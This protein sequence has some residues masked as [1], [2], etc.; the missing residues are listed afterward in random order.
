MYVLS[1]P[2]SIAP[3]I[4]RTRSLLFRPFR[5]SSFLKLCAVAVF[6]E[7]YSSGNFNSLHPHHTPNAHFAADSLTFQSNPL[8]IAFILAAALVVVG[9]AIA[10]FYLLVRLRFALFH[11][12]IHQMRLLAPGWR[13][14]REQSLRFFLLSLAVGFVFLAVFLAAAVPFFVGFL[15]L[16]RDYHMSGD[17]PV[18]EFLTLLLPFIP[19]L[20][21][22]AIAGV[23]VDMILRDFMLPHMALENATSGQAWAA[24]RAHIG[25]EK[26]AFFVYGLL[27]IVLP[28]V[29]TI[30]LVLVLLIP[31][32]ILFGALAVMMGG[33]HVALGDATGLMFLVRIFIEAVLGLIFFALALFLTICLGGPLSIAVRNYALVFYGGRYQ[34]LGN[35]LYPPPPAP[36]PAPVPA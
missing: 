7:G 26:G 36:T 14:Y 28:I 4:E 18:A 12:L 5:W 17:F 27:R 16:F 10:L 21:V 11:C 8:L 19:V 15:H 9:L 23:A 22:F 24:A 6:T 30:A 2:E 34:A 32:I 33:V 35:I 1:A 13:L 29:A 20:L 25:R 31:G 3:A